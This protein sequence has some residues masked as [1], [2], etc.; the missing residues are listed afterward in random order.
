MATATE[1]KE[2]LLNGVSGNYNVKTIGN[3]F[4]LVVRNQHDLIAKFEKYDDLML[5]AKEI[6]KAAGKDWV[7][8]EQFLSK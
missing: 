3:G 5:A 1:K 2:V 8:L 6:V 4:K 7:T